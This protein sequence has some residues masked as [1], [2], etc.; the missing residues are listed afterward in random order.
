MREFVT[1]GRNGFLEDFHDVDKLAER[2]LEVLA[3]PEKYRPLGQA[4][5]NLVRQR[6][7]LRKTLPKLV[8][9]FQHVLE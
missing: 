7:D 5:A 2:A 6:Y 4:G 8:N 9:L 1:S 3:D